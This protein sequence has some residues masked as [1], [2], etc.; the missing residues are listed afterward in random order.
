MRP[1]Q[2]QKALNAHL[3]DDIVITDIE[4]APEPEGLYKV[5]AFPE[6]TTVPA[7]V[8]EVKGEVFQETYTIF[9][10]L[11]AQT[12]A[13]GRYEVR[14]ESPRQETIFRSAISVR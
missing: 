9:L 4:E 2:I 7:W 1:E 10:M 6:G 8:D 13:P 11:E 3:P 12:L 5:G 14:I